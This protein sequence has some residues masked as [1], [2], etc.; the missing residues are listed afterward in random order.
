MIDAAAE[1]EDDAMRVI[2]PLLNVGFADDMGQEE[3]ST[4]LPHLGLDDVDITLDDIRS[5]GETKVEDF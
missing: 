3:I 2:N 4:A 1:N 5:V